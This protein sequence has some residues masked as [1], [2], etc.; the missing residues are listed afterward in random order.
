MDTS[1]T[2]ASSKQQAGEQMAH[3]VCH[4]LHWKDKAWVYSYK[5]RTGHFYQAIQN[6]DTT[7]TLCPIHSKSTKRK[8]QMSLVLWRFADW[9]AT[10][11]CT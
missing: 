2:D 10:E 3:G 8:R 5:R 7:A 4:D 11:F 6:P 9:I 1:V